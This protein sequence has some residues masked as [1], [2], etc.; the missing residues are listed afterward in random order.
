L[1]RATD[2]SFRKS[3]TL[4]RGVKANSKDLEGELTHT[5]VVWLRVPEA[6]RT[7]GISR[8]MLYELIFTRVI[9]SALLRKPGNSRGIRLISAES[10][11]A[12]IDANVT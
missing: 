7:R 11:D 6:V 8:S 5:P 12:Y 3:Q 1:D 9:K 4:K 2:S 10:L